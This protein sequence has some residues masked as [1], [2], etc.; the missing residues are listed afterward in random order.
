MASNVE[1]VYL[2]TSVISALFDTRTP[3]RQALTEL[4][5]MELEKYSVFISELVLSEI[6]AARDVYRERMINIVS[7]FE[8]LKIDDTVETLAEQYLNYEIF[9]DRFWDDALHVAVA[10]VN[11]MNY[12]VSWNYKHLVKVKTRRMVNLV[13]ELNGYTMIEIIAP[14]EL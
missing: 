9:P 13:N 14:P 4:F 6:N 7:N 3:E 11:K 2:D 8:Q 1:R 5:W 10:S 12:L